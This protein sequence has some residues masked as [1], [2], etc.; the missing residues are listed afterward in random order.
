MPFML[1]QS[2]KVSDAQLV[3][4]INRIYTSTTG[5]AAYPKAVALLLLVK[6]ALDEFVGGGRWR[7]GPD[8]RQE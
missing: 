5:N 1:Q 3:K 7:R 6:A 4:D 8:R 2:S